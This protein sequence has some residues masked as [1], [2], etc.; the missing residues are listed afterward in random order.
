MRKIL[1]VMVFMVAMIAL[2]IGLVNNAA[3][4][5]KAKGV[6]ACS[7]AG[8]WDYG[9][10]NMAMIVPLDPTGKMFTVTVYVAQPEEYN[11]TLQG[12]VEKIGRNLYA[13]TLY[14]YVVDGTG[15]IIKRLVLILE[16]EMN[17]CDTV[18]ECSCW[19]HS[20]FIFNEKENNRYRLEDFSGRVFAY[21]PYNL[22]LNKKDVFKYIESLDSLNDFLI[23]EIY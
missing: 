7:P 22:G 20:N 2:Q 18:G 1:L 8:A 21:F 3:A 10:G 4:K 19:L 5:G 11:Y 9:D 12:I 17:D 23:S 15:K 14:R 6:V 16:T 13:Y